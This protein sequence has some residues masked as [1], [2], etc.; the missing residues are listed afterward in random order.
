MIS[1]QTHFAAPERSPQEEILSEYEKFCSLPMVVNLL[2]ALSTMTAILNNNRQVVYANASFMDF[3]KAG[4]ITAI[5][6]MRPGEIMG[7]VHSD[8]IPAGCGTAEACSVCG[9]IHAV[10]ESRNESRKVSREAMLTTRSSGG[11]VSFDLMITASPFV[12]EDR[13]YTIVS[14]G[15]ISDQ[16]RKNALEKIFFH[17]IINTA[18]GI[19]GLFKI[20]GRVTDPDE[21]KN[22]FGIG[23]RLSRDLIDEIVA[24]RELLLAESGELKINTAKLGSQAFLRGVSEQYRYHRVSE[25]KDISIDETG[26]DIQFVSD[27][28]ILKRVVGNML[29]NALEATPAG[30]AVSFSITGDPES[31]FIRVKNRGFMDRETRLHMFQ[32][33]FSTK[34][35]NRGLGAY[36]MKL[37]TERYLGGTISFE[38]SEEEGT[39]FIV[40]ISRS[41][42]GAGPDE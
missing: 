34:G 20:A 18:G 14:F 19:R 1:K 33:S 3:I 15:D 17:D 13:M 26:G 7:C 30:G 31:V 25:G 38:S 12:V 37:L 29:K 40:K 41:G 2:D 28:I 23:E 27:E 11:D 22:M 5:L 42:P 35:S 8:E 4:E 16:K 6:G 32:R 24:Q 10:L 36:S 9:A 21:I 39:T